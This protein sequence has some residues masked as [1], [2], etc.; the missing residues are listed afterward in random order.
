MPNKDEKI[1]ELLELIYEEIKKLNEN[2]QPET[3]VWKLK[4]REL[5][6]KHF[7]NQLR[8][9]SQKKAYIKMVED[10]AK[11]HNV[12]VDDILNW[13]TEP[14]RHLFYSSCKWVGIKDARDKKRLSNEIFEISS[15]KKGKIT[16]TDKKDDDLKLFSDSSNVDS[17]WNKD[18][19][20]VKF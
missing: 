18:D 5:I 12:S 19:E 2:L 4:D 20:D 10:I 11:N 6:N 17:I 13:E 14:L 1:M 8:S 3:F 15:S 7:F 9:T 16:S